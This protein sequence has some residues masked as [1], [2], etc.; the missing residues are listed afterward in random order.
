MDIIPCVTMLLLPLSSSA[1]G[2]DSPATSANLIEK[3]RG[4]CAGF[5]S[6]A[7]DVAEEAITRHDITGDD[8]PE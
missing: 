3:A 7:F 4:E 5:N 2:D 1:K 6:G 8:R